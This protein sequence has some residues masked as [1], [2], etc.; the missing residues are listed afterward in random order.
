MHLFL[1]I[2]LFVAGRVQIAPG[3]IDRDGIMESFAYDSFYFQ[4][5]AIV[6]A[7]LL[8]GGHLGQW[9][10]APQLVHTKI[11]ALPFAVL[12]PVFGYG[13]LSA[14]PYNLVS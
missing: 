11:L 12:G 8:Q 3:L 5:R 2:V 13:T 14:E 10:S 4:R 9:A 1:A 7:E 6:L